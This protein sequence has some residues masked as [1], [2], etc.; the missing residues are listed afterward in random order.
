MEINPDDYLDCSDLHNGFARVKCKDC[1]HEYLQAFA[2]KR[3]HF[4]LSCHQK[5]VVEFGGWLSHVSKC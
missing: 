1:G 5:R 2:C 3:H 4:C